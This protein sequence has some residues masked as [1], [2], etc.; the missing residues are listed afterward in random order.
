MKTWKDCVHT[1]G[2]KTVRF[3]NLS[4][5]TTARSCAK[6]TGSAN[7][8]WTEPKNPQ[9]F[10]KPVRQ[11]DN[12]SLREERRSQRTEG[13]VRWLNPESPLARAFENFCFYVLRKL[14][15]LFKKQLS[16]RQQALD[17]SS[18]V[19][20]LCSNVCFEVQVRSRSNSCRSRNRDALARCY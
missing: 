7:K 5:K 1:S 6:S 4:G 18:R 20:S 10:Q 3:L 2:Q 13:A 12:S 9:G 11:T 15:E 19:H 16:L 8:T 17:V 14:K